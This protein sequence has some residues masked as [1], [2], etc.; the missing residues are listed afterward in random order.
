[1][2]RFL[3]Q[4]LDFPAG[5]SRFLRAPQQKRAASKRGSPKFCFFFSDVKVFK[6]R[7]QAAHCL[8]HDRARRRKVEALEEGGLRAE[9][10]PGV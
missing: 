9:D 1:M 10:G 3:C 6:R 5:R 4:P 7:F 8:F 2:S